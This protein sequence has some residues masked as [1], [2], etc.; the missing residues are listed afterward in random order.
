MEKPPFNYRRKP[1][2]ISF[3]PVYLVCF[4]ISYLLIDNSTLISKEITSRIITGP[5][6]L[7]SVPVRNLPYGIIFSVPFIIYGI[8]R[9]LWNIM[10]RYEF[11]STDIRL[12]TGS[13]SRKESFSP[14]TDFYEVSFRQN[15]IE[16]PFG[17]GCLILAPL[18]G[19]RRLIIRGV[20]K[21]KTVVD[22]LRSGLGSI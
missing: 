8:Y 7:N 18:K 14:V 2:F 13:L 3:L 5:G 17:I 21:V 22:A 11:S 16:T 9:L 19:G 4:G 6:I 1:S 10:S 15:L 20:Y 12:L